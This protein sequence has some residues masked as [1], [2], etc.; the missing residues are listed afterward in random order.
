MADDVA[1]MYAGR[2]VEKAEI[3]E[4]FRDPQHPYT[5]GLLRSVPSIYV[6]KERLEAIPGQP[7]DLT[8][9]F[10]GCPFA[11]RCADVQD[12]CLSE[13]PPEFHLP[14]GRMSNCWNCEKDA[15]TITP[16]EPAG[17]RAGAI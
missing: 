8:K 2:P 7:P 16:R 1:V 5:K 11:P 3:G 17:S 4:L 13:D 14:S 12:R 10:T 15:K 9:G 6:R